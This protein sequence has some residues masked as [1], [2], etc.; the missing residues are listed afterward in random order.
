V[1][2]PVLPTLRV[3]ILFFGRI[4]ELVGLTEESRE[5]PEATTLHE[6]FQIYIDRFPQLADFRPS[7]VAS[8]NQEFAAWNTPLANG[9][10]VAFLP[11]VSGG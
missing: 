10:E 11:P 1:V 5:I 4:R 7:L 8:R 9:D 6:L 2:P 3:K